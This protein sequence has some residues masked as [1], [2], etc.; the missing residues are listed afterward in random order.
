MTLA[1]KTIYQ[2]GT[3][4]WSYAHWH[5]QFYPKTIK[6]KDWFAYYVKKFS[7]VEI[8]AT[9]YHFFKDETYHH[10]Y[11]QAP[12]GFQY[13]LKI[14]RL[15]T[16]RKYL[17]AVSRYIN[18]FE[19]SARLLKEK[20]GLLLMQLPPNMPYE[21]NRLKNALAAFQDAS[22][23]V[24]EFRHSKWITDEA[25]DL[26]KQYNATFC[27]VD[28]STFQLKDPIVTS[29][30]AYIRLHG[31]DVGY[32]YHYTKADLMTLATFMK[33]LVKKGAKTVY[34]FFNNDGHAYAPNNALALKQRI[35]DTVT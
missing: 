3:S 22:K 5:D 12:A 32:D 23:V 4:G 31:K 29:N 26:L 21:L 19:K 35:E 20:L 15:I 8:N 18:N 11:E 2:I 9:F 17:K 33:K 25:I 28:S 1:I 34:V 14:P 24:V 13:A 10:W 16:H 27:C 7:T 6:K 30:N